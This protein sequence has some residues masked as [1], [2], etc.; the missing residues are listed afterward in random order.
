LEYLGKEIVITQDSKP[1]SWKWAVRLNET[2]VRMG[3]AKTRAA[4][5]KS[6]VMAV[7]QALSLSKAGLPHQPGI[8]KA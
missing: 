1:D 3:T 4:A 7:D 2:T 8:A 6:S 5:M